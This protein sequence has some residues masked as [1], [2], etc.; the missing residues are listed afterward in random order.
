MGMEAKTLFV[1]VAVSLLILAAVP[2]GAT[3]I[4]NLTTVTTIHR[5]VNVSV[6]TYGI[7]L[8]YRYN[9]SATL[10][11]KLLPNGT[12]EKFQPTFA[13]SQEVYLA[14]SNG[15][16]GF[17]AGDIFLCSSDSIFRMPGGSGTAV[18]FA[19]PSPGSTVE[20]IAFDTTGAWGHLLYALTGD[21][22]VWAV[23]ASGSPKLVSSLGPNLMPEGLAVAPPGFGDFGGDLLVTMEN[24]HS[25]VAIRQNSTSFQTILATFPGQAPERVIVV[26]PGE[27]L[28]VAKYDLNIVVR[29]PASILASYAARPLVITEGEN[30]QTGS[31]NALSAVGTKVTSTTILSD[32]SSPHFEGATF[33]PAGYFPMLTSSTST[34]ASSASFT[35]TV[36]S[37]GRSLSAPVLLYLVVGAAVISAGSI[38]IFYRRSRRISEILGTDNSSRDVSSPKV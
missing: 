33:I 21:G 6:T 20:Y 34:A 7:I 25:L 36:T 4:P 12:T 26:A 10:L 28:L 38:V 3:Q 23:N 31:I 8:S 30:G 24:S 37:S 32:P 16:A 5:P 13:G 35:S 9:D 22:G 27:D 17:K 29:L 15:S 11:S 1:T 2:L 19:K 18:L 14:E